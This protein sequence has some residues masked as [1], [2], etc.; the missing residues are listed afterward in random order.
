MRAV[1]LIAAA[2]AILILTALVIA[3]AQWAAGYVRSASNGRVELA[4]AS[5]TIWNGSAVVVIA[6][7]AETGASRASLPERLSWRLSPWALLAGQID[8]ALTHPSAL[9]QPL[10]DQ[11]GIVREDSDTRADHDA[12]AGIVA[13][14]AWSSVEHSATRRHPDGFMGSP[15]GRAWPLARALEWRVA[16]RIERP[17]ACVANGSLPSCKPTA[18]GQEL[19]WN[20]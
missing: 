3:P 8:L 2:L 6:S 14:R 17:D 12:I 11:C 16:V 9:S 10:T 20:Y 7:P 1:S 5:G 18:S 4:E 13:G 19:N 15:R